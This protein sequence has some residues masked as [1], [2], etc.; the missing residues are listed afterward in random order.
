[1]YIGECKIRALEATQVRRTKYTDR[2]K[3]DK[4]KERN[5]FTLWKKITHSDFV[6]GCQL[7]FAENKDSLKS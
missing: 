7:L 5:L 3:N 2:K 6:L 1:M 4:T